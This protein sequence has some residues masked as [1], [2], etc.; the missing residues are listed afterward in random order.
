MLLTS[1]T[2]SRKY[3]SLVALL[4]LCGACLVGSGAGRRTLLQ[5]LPPAVECPGVVRDGECYFCASGDNNG[6]L[7]NERGECSC[8]DGGQ[9]LEVPDGS[10]DF[11]GAVLAPGVG[12]S[13]DANEVDDEVE[14]DDDDDDFGGF[15]DDDDDDDFGGFDDDDDDDE[16]DDF[17]FDDDDDDFGGF[18]ND[19][20]D[21]DDDESGDDDESDDDDD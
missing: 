5:S 18:D 1:K 2:T 20:D 15:D 14:D 7:V 8:G 6:I 17:R 16:L 9:C 3:T 19:F 10:S 13:D 12:Q 11:S 21:N 4:G